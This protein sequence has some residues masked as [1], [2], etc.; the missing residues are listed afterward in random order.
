M[1]RLFVVRRVVVLVTVLLLS[2]AASALTVEEPVTPAS[3]KEKD[4]KFSIKAEL[5]QDGLV[6]FTI[7]HRLA[8]A[9]YLVAHFELRDGGTTLV[10][11]DTPAY[12]R[13]GEATYHVAV[14]QKQLAES[15]FEV[16][17]HAFDESGGRPVALPGGTIY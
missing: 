11:T 4:S 16:S 2:N 7:T 1:P 14:S 5:R 12:V 15:K 10:K 6:H 17:E 8:R 13:E 3:V 9:Q